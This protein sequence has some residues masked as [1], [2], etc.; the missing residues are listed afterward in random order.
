MC[1]S[2]DGRR[3]PA[4]EWQWQGRSW[5]CC[6]EGAGLGTAPPSNREVELQAAVCQQNGWGS[7]TLLLGL[8]K[9]PAAR[10]CL[11]PS[12]APCLHSSTAL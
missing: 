2:P 1:R 3:L 4:L 11:S 8:M 10:C 12:R 9:P 7:D 6:L 5:K